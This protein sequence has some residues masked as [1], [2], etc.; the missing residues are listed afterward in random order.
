MV[1]V[2]L[3]QGFYYLITGVWPIL[4]MRSFLKVTGSKTDLWLVRMVGA[5]I[6]AISLGL[7]LAG[8]NRQFNPP[9]IVIAMS[10]TLAFIAIELIYTAKRVI[11]PVYLADAVVE[12]GL[13]LW[14]TLA[15]LFN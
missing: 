12:L 9:L 2:A 15:L 8:I 6:I 7:I 14:W 3:V 13:L 11:S 4:H 5:L 10:S 1:T